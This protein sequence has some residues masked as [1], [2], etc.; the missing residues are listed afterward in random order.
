MAKPI[1]LF[2]PGAGASSRS[3]WMQGWAKLLRTK[4][5]VVL[6]D[7]SYTE[8]RRRAPDRLPKLIT[9]HRAAWDRV[10]AK[11][12]RRRIILIG[13][14]MGSR[15][16]C[17]LALEVKAHALVCL[18][19]PLAGGGDRTKLRDEVLRALTTPILFITG[20]RDPLCPLD[21]LA[22][23]RA[24]MKAPSQ[25][26]G[27]EGGDHSLHVSKR[28]LDDHGDTQSDVDRRLVAVIESFLKRRGSSTK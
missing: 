12:P 20:T 5:D 9:A 10:K 25:L 22:Q 24:S 4:G 18:G 15:V 2:A 1:F 11:H 27:V 6:M 8:E 26:E 14:S 3:P 13:K 19:Y 21:L 7:Y 23:V 28:S 17:H 16:G